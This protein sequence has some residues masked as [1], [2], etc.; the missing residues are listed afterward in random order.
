VHNFTTSGKTSSFYAIT[1]NLSTS[2]GTVSYNGLTLTQCLKLES[3]TKVTF[4]A[5]KSGTLTLVCNSG[6]TGKILV[7]GVARTASNGV[8]TVSLS[9]GS[10]TIT[11]S[12]TGNLYYIS[13][14]Q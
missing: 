2:K 13:L 5:A 1:G 9:A 12:D 10:H 11:K 8:V 3:S 7:D 6:W 14:T 4:T